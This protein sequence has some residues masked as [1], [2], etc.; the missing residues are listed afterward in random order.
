MG[1]AVINKNY[2]AELQELTNL[3]TKIKTSV[4]SGR[5]ILIKE[6][7]QQLN[8]LIL[9]GWSYALGKEQELEESL[10][11]N[12]YINQ[13][14]RVIDDLQIE[15]GYCAERYRSVATGSKDDVESI[16]EYHKTF[17]ELLRINGKII[18]LDPDAE[19]P[20][21]EMPKDYVDFWS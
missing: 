17:A 9:N 5:E 7:K 19:L 2:D 3:A 8:E 4:I 11:P 16:A 13:R 18:A 10:L 15:L 6:Y 20:D 12:R 14:N 1:F 21:A